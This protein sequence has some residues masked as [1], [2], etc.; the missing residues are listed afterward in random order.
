MAFIRTQRGAT[1]VMMLIW[2]LIF[3]SVATLAIKL[4]PIYLDD[5]AVEASLEGLKRDSALPEKDDKQIVGSLDNFFRVNSVY[6]F[7]KDNIVIE[8]EDDSHVKVI[9][10]YEVRTKIV[11]NIDA[12]LSFKHE[13]E[14]RQ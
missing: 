7:N 10:D 3:V 5:F 4:I 8:R 13:L 2:L 14:V 1:P 9:L 6:S 11:Y 12:V